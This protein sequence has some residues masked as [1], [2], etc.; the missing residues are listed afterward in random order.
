[1]G[2]CSN[3]CVCARVW[4]CVVVARGGVCPS[5]PWKASAVLSVGELKLMLMQRE[6]P[7]KVQPSYPQSEAFDFHRFRAVP[8]SFVFNAIFFL[9]S[10]FPPSSCNFETLNVSVPIHVSVI[11]LLSLSFVSSV[12]PPCPSMSL[13]PSLEVSLEALGPCVCVSVWAVH[14]WVYC[15]SSLNCSPPL[16]YKYSPLPLSCHFINHYIFTGLKSFDFTTLAY[17]ALLLKL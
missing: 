14:C 1:M 2:S 13:F 11:S 5:W 3:A 10:L 4:V 16:F 7:W 17:F 9:P 6:W 8:P 12:C 15:E